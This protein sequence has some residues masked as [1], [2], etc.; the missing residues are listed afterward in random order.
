MDSLD[1]Q[2]ETLLEKYELKDILEASDMTEAS[3]LRFLVELDLVELPEA[4]AQN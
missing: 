3:A 2:I 4:Q 1:A